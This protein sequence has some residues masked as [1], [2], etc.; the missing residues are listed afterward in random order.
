MSHI[1]EAFDASQAEIVP[2]WN[3]DG[4]VEDIQADAALKLFLGQCRGHVSD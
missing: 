2:T 4:V 1:P 3:G